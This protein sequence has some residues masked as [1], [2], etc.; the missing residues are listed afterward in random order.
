M[1]PLLYPKTP[2]FSIPILRRLPH[3]FRKPFLTFLTLITYIP[4]LA[5]S[6][7]HIATLMTVTG[8]SMYPLLNTDHNRTT[9]RDV[10]FVDLRNPGENLK[11]GMV[12]A[13]WLVGLDSQL[14]PWKSPCE[15]LLDGYYK[16]M[17][18]HQSLISNRPVE[19]SRSPNSSEKL[20]IKRI[21]ALS[22]DTII[23]KPP[24]PFQ[25]ETIPPGHIW[26]EG[27]HPESDRWS[28]D[29]NYYG[30]VS[31]HLQENIHLFCLDR[32]III[33]HE[34]FPLIHANPHSW[35]DF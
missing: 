30:P 11:R 31:F 22:G 24:Y 13:F 10:V 26:V 32:S 23:T 1:P 19:K 8:A 29:S 16:K 2:F 27:E 3:G 14:R 25:N 4:I 17:T 21:I 9:R 6:Q 35:I 33:S 7:T 34:S 18:A 5:F 12:V 28:R 15:S 20:A